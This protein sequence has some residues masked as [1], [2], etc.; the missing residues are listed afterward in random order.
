MQGCLVP[1][2]GP[3]SPGSPGTSAETTLAF[4]LVLSQW[5]DL[6]WR[7]RGGAPVEFGWGWGSG[8]GVRGSDEM[9]VRPPYQFCLCST[10]VLQHPAGN[11]KS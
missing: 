3:G 8:F 2:G 4:P 6:S 5:N 7:E 9:A 11:G 10:L 1:E